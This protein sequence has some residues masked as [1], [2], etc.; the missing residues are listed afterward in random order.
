MKSKDKYI[1]KAYGIAK[2]HVNFDRL[3]M[4]ITLV[5]IQNR[6]RNSILMINKNII[7]FKRKHF[8]QENVKVEQISKNIL[9]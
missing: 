3:K 9:N 5:F 2:I 8:W 1:S 4:L 6:T 7:Y